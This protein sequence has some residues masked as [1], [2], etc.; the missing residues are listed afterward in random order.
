MQLFDIFTIVGVHLHDA[1]NTFFLPLHRIVYAAAFGQ[2]AGIH[3]HK[4]QLADEGIG[5]Q[6]ECQRRELFI[7]RRAADHDIV[8]LV[9]AFHR[10]NVKRRGH[11]FNHRVQHALHPFVAECGTAQHR[12]NFAGHGAQAQAA[13]DLFFA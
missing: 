1:A 6:L 13:N 11:Q 4:G 10:W 5:H 3:S 7:V 9:V 2:Y 12:L 8:A